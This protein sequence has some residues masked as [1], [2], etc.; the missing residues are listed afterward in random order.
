MP[1]V[2]DSRRAFVLVRARVDGGVQ[3]DRNGQGYERRHAADLGCETTLAG[4]EARRQ[5]LCGAEHAR[6]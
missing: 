5:P 4:G 1:P 2:R 3:R 6:L